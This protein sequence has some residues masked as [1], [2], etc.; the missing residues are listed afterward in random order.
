VVTQSASGRPGTCTC[1]QPDRLTVQSSCLCRQTCGQETMFALD[2]SL[3]NNLVGPFSTASSAVAGA[4]RSSRSDSAPVQ[5]ERTRYQNLTFRCHQVP[6][7]RTTSGTDEAGH[8]I[9]A[10]SPRTVRITANAAG[11]RKA[12]F[13]YLLSI[14][15]VGSVRGHSRT[16]CSGSSVAA[17]RMRRAEPL[18]GHPPTE[19]GSLGSFNVERFSAGAGSL[20]SYGS[21]RMLVA[22][23]LPVS[24]EAGQCRRTGREGLES[25]L[26]SAWT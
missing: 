4:V 13:I 20:P 10:T 17:G 2:Q 7:A 1:T 9:I 21:R 14:A 22:G 18:G 24:G 25:T 12:H 15:L 3:A 6:S 8:R 26:R 5:R 11:T 16:T 23:E 19:V